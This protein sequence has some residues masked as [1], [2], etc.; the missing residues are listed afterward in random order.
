MGGPA[1]NRYDL[2]A[3]PLVPRCARDNAT[4]KAATAASIS[5]PVVNRLSEKR[6]VLLASSGVSPIARRT[7][8]GSTRP[9]EHAD[10]VEAAIPA[11][12]SAITIPSAS[13]PRN[14]TFDVF[15]KRSAR[16]PLIVTSSGS[17]IDPHR[18]R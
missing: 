7:L 11:R 3:P 18:S 15:G 12:S 6:T 4:D 17:S 13:P 1:K 9:D 8:L 16:A 5:V 14:V 10:P 2:A